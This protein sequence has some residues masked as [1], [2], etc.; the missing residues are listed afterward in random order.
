MG[1][2]V[3]QHEWEPR[4]S[5]EVKRVV[6]GIIEQA[7]GKKLPKGYELLNV[8]LNMEEPKA[9]CFWNAPSRSELEGLLRQVNPTTTHIVKETQGLYGFDKIANPTFSN[10]PFS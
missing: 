5:D 6:S 9:Y 10:A 8:F 4:R 1:T 7:A 3:V 2:F